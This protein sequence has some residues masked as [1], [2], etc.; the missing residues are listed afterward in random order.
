MRF[1][2]QGRGILRRL[3]YPIQFS[4][5]PVEAVE[6]VFDYRILPGLTDTPQHY[7]DAICDGLESTEELSLPIPQNHSESV[8]RNYLSAVGERL[9][10]QVGS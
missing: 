9:H 7:L 8:I 4:A 2:N 6:H 1:D 5:N 3:I 10:K